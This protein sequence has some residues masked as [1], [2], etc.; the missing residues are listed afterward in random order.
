MKYTGI[1]YRPPF[2]AQSLLLQVTQGCSHNRCAFCTMYRDIPF[3]I[4][5]LEQIEKDLDEARFYNPHIKR[6][7]L[8]NGDP[9]VLSADQLKSI[10]Q[11]IHKKLPEV[12]T[13][14]MYASI[15]NIKTKTDRELRELRELGINEL[16]IGVESGLDSA[17]LAMEKGYTSE[18]ALHEL[19]R[20]KKAGIAYGANIIF[21]VAGPDLRK[22]NALKT[23]ELL[24]QTE[25]YLIFTGTLHADN[26]CP[27]YEKIQNGEFQ[28]STIGEYIEEEEILLKALTL[29]QSYYFGLHP[30]NVIRMHGIL[31]QD[32][33]A[34][35]EHIHQRREQLSVE[36]LNAIPQ[37]FG[38]GGIIL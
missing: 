3:Q 18:E 26:G 37:R 1:T 22:E 30:S 20:L 34:L 5:T 27:L 2:E 31:A 15:Q 4:E 38:E 19:L 11:L 13:I 8:E 14:A 32:K 36:Q 16:N 28:E 29:Q 6:V 33:E 21:G 23:A 17:L 9:F 12:Q 25:P 10:A 35:L 24:N 7:F